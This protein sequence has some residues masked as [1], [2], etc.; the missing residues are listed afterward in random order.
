[1]SVITTSPLLGAPAAVVGGAGACITVADGGSSWPWGNWVTILSATTSSTTAIAGIVVGI[2]T[3]A[4][5]QAEVEIGYGA[6]PTSLGIVRLQG[7]NSGSGD[8]SVLMFPIPIGGTSAGAIPSGSAIKFRV[9]CSLTSAH[10]FGLLYYENFDSDAIIYRPLTCAPLGADSL[11]VTPSGTTWTYSSWGTLFA[12]VGHEIA[13]AGLAV[14]NP[15]ANADYEFQLGTGASPTVFTMLASSTQAASAG[16]LWNLWLPAVHP[17]AADSSVKVRMR[18]NGT[19][20]TDHRVALL[21]YDD[22]N[23]LSIPAPPEPDTIAAFYPRR[24]RQFLLPSSESNHK[25][26]LGKMEL[27]CQPGIGLSTGQGSDP[28]VMFQL[29]TNGGA[30]FGYERWR[31]AGAMGNYQQRVTWNRNGSYRNAVGKIVVTDPV[32]WQFLKFIA[33]IR[34]GPS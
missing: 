21:Y 25:M 33:D 32:D 6:T 11:S 1:M 2:S 30:S 22:T 19:D 4:A 28:Q 24:E 14:S 16:K 23:F 7:P 15:T 5:M 26:Q 34:E 18:K 31:S 27:L 3:Y 13:I 12:G 10:T 8:H 17:L 9:R 29:S 20:T